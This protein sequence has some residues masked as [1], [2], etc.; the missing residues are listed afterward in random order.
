MCIGWLADHFRYHSGISSSSS[1]GTQGGQRSFS[2][3][4]EE[5]RKLTSTSSVH[6]FCVHTSR[7]KHQPHTH[8]KGNG[9]RGSVTITPFWP[10]S[11]PL[12][13][14]IFFLHKKQWRKGDC[15]LYHFPQNRI[16]RNLVQVLNDVISHITQDSE[17]LCQSHTCPTVHS[18]DGRDRRTVIFLYVKS[19]GYPDWTHSAHFHNLNREGFLKP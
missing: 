18:C 3:S 12:H 6:T 10:A 7:P 2:S 19:H 8:T 1:S 16:G 14:T 11:H 15:F 4:Y 9:R 5:R 13:Q 17:L